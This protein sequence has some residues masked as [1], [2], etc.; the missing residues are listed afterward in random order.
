MLLSCLCPHLSENYFQN[1]KKMLHFTEPESADGPGVRASGGRS[2][3]NIINS[4]NAYFAGEDCGL[5]YFKILA[6]PLAD[7]CP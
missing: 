2:D 5:H 4:P 1:M 3:R 6:R 7:C